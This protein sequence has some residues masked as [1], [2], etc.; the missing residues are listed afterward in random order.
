LKAADEMIAAGLI[1]DARVIFS[2]LHEDTIDPRNRSLIESRL[3]ALPKPES[4]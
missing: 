2:Q 4:E 3:N 1:A